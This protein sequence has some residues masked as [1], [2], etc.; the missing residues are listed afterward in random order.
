MTS[1]ELTITILTGLLVNIVTAMATYWWTTQRDANRNAE[2]TRLANAKVADIAVSHLYTSYVQSKRLRFD[3]LTEVGNVRSGKMTPEVY[4]AILE[5]IAR[6]LEQERVAIVPNILTW[7]AF[8]LPDSYSSQ[9][10][11]KVQEQD[12][13]LPTGDTI[14]Q[15]R[16]PTKLARQEIPGIDKKSDKGL[17]ASLPFANKA[18]RMPGNLKQLVEVI[19]SDPAELAMRALL[20]GDIAA[21]RSLGARTGEATGHTEKVAFGSTLALVGEPSG[22]A[23]L[24]DALV[25]HWHEMEPD[26]FTVALGSVVQGAVR[27]DSEAE[28]LQAIEPAIIKRLEGTLDN[29]KKKAFILNQIQKLR[30]S[31]KDYQSG[32]RDLERAVELDPTESAYWHNLALCYEQTNELGLAEQAIRKALSLR[33]DDADILALAARLLSKN[34]HIEE[35]EQ[36]SIRAAE[37]DPLRA[38]LSQL[39]DLVDDDKEDN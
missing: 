33:G 23:L 13:S 3:V 15:S 38:M 26:E 14:L 32:I 36:L 18:G 8:V 5:G 17:G 28:V 7:K 16:T 35:A 11:Q 12:F 4:S 19:G 34:G 9:L 39:K 37:I 2:E 25:Q 27:R 22:I 1:S 31:I 6:S 20:S 21:L 10:I 30:Y 29:N 24:Q